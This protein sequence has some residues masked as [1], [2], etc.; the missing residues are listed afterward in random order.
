[1]KNHRT[2]SCYKCSE[3]T[4]FVIDSRS[5]VDKLTILF[6]C[7]NPQCK[8]SVIESSFY[9]NIETGIGIGELFIRRTY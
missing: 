9:I 8:T 5:N 1:M 6:C 4:N 3:S 2:G 7:D